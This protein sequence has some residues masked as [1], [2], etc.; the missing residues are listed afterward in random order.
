MDKQKVMGIV[1]GATIVLAIVIFLATRG[2]GNGGDGGGG[3]A[4]QG[5][6]LP[7]VVNANTLGR[8]TEVHAIVAAVKAKGEQQVTRINVTGP[9]SC[10]VTGADGRKYKLVRKGGAWEVSPDKPA[11][12]K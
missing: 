10:E 12:G 8:P 9:E 3:A 4:P 11:G 1:A 5:E 2:G 7:E 6:K